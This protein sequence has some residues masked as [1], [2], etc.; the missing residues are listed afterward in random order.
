MP[1]IVCV[2]WASTRTDPLLGGP[3]D[4]QKPR[5]GVC[6]SRCFR[7][8]QWAIIGHCTRPSLAMSSG[9]HLGSVMGRYFVWRETHERFPPCCNFYDKSASRQSVM[10]WV[11][12]GFGHLGHLAEVP[13]AL[14]HSVIMWTSWANTSSL[15]QFR[16]THPK[17]R[18]NQST[19][20]SF[21]HTHRIW[22]SLKLC[23]DG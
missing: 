2:E 12:F 9:C 19:T 11:Y 17:N 3:L 6:W 22:T 13:V 7:T 16:Q 1:S 21:P 23:R 10:F 5:T 14:N 4:R 18:T 15:Q 20:C 8:G